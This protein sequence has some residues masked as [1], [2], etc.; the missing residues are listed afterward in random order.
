MNSVLSPCIRQ[1]CLDE[2]DICLGCF[3]VLAE[4]TGWQRAG[5]PQRLLIL[6]AVE[7]RRQNHKQKYGSGLNV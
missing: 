1:C 5:D 7:K 6:Q 2:N 4:I 3:R